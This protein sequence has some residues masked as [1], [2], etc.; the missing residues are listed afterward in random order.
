MA[1][2]SLSNRV[3]EGGNKGTSSDIEIFIFTHKIRAVLSGLFRDIL[4]DNAGRLFVLQLEHFLTGR[5]AFSRLVEDGGKV[6][7]ELLLCLIFADLDAGVGVIVD[8][9]RNIELEDLRHL[10]T[11]R[12]ASLLFLRPS[13]HR[14]LGAGRKV[15]L[16]HHHPQ[17][18]ACLVNLLLRHVNVEIVFNNQLLRGNVVNPHRKKVLVA[19]RHLAHVAQNVLLPIIF[20]LV[21]RGRHE[22]HVRINQE[23]VESEKLESVGILF[24]GRNGKALAELDARLIILLGQDFL[25]VACRWKLE[26]G[27]IDRGIWE[28]VKPVHACVCV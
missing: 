16:L 25:P 12:L 27:M 17:D 1:N 3:L 14:G 4:E 22:G 10:L 28:C 23:L 2:T 20:S 9:G 15:L 26:A 8:D 24:K 7:D 13:R 21:F 5:V 18:G 11:V 19:G 6:R